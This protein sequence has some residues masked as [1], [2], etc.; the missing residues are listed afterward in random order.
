MI[1]LLAKHYENTTISDQKLTKK[2]QNVL[3]S[4]LAFYAVSMAIPSVKRS[5]LLI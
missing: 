1:N 5:I 4:F 2:I 3:V